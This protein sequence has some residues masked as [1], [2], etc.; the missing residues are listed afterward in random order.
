MPKVSVTI[1]VYVFMTYEVDID[2]DE[3]SYEDA[4]DQA[5]DMDIPHKP[6]INVQG[7]LSV[8]SGVRLHMS[9]EPFN[10]DGIEVEEVKG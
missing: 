8:P 3:E 2:L 7:G 6:Y 1:P 10:H 4:E 5:L 9:A